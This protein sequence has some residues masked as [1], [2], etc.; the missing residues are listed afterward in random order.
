[1]II[2]AHIHLFSAAVIANVGQRKELVAELHLQADAAARRTGP[3]ALRQ[4]LHL[5]GVGLALHL[6]T[7]KAAAVSKTNAN[8]MDISRAFAF[9]ATA[10]TLHP[11][12][13]AIPAELSKLRAGGVRALKLCSFSQGF[14]LDGPQAMTM[15]AHIQDF[16]RRN[17]NPFFVVLDTY[18]G[19]DRHFGSAPAHT[20]TPQRIALLTRCFPDICFVGAHMGGLDAPIDTL[21]RDLPAAPNLYLDTSNAAHVLTDDAFMRLLNIHGPERILF[22]TDWPWFHPREEIERIDRLLIKSGFSKRECELVF[23]ANAAHLLGL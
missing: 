1:M 21:V 23:G 13:E 17:R 11:Q 4:A 9:I 7:A 6:P 14:Q 22:G 18:C 5:A 12:Y 16:N 8:A 10:G 2:D 15:W 19:A 3:D 20:A